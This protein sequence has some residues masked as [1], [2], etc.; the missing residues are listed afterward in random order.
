[1][2]P[3]G[4]K[5]LRV[6]GL[7]IGTSA[8]LDLNDNDLI[9]DYSGT[10]PMSGVRAWI[11]TA[12][13]TGSWNGYGLTSTTAKNRPG[14]ATTLGL[15]EASDFKTING[16]GATFDG[17]VLA[18]N[19]VLVKYT[20]SGDADFSGQVNFND[21][22]RVQNGFGQTSGV[23]F[24]S[25]DFNYDGKVDFN[26]FLM[27]QNNFGQTMPMAR[28]D[29]SSAPVW[30]VPVPPPATPT[31][32]A[33][34][35]ASLSGIAFNDSN[36]NGKYDKSDTLAAGKTVWLDLD[37]DGVRDANEPT[38]VTDAK[39]KYTFKHLAA[40]TYRVRRLVSRGY[41]E[42]TPIRYLTLSTGQA[43]TNVAIGSKM[44]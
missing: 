35:T 17:E 28:P 27:L 21:F 31:P 16:S 39:G 25:G 15:M 1:M 18:G 41:V 24:F 3:G 38:V 5:L 9:L 11:G 30:T 36:K 32:P 14:G 44:K 6:G 13:G 19:A 40:G 42:S 8:K 22:L 10:S 29:E 26:D 33:K 43:L 23:S 4:G 34:N 37:N 20:L 12:R 7:S 2:P